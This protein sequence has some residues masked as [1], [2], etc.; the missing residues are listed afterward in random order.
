MVSEKLEFN[1]GTLKGDEDDDWELDDEEYEYLDELWLE[2]GML[3]FDDTFPDVT[4]NVSVPTV[5]VSVT[6]TVDDNVTTTDRWRVPDKVE[7]DIKK[8]VGNKPDS[9]KMQ[10][11]TSKN[12]SGTKTV[13]ENGP[14]AISNSGKVKTSGTEEVQS[15]KK[16]SDNGSD[17]SRL[18]CSSCLLGVSLFGITLLALV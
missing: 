3:D 13:K 5:Y 17:S 8:P 12:L 4:E 2:D 6:P 15:I 11:D 14:N 18:V 9:G 1:N 10:G 7:E 16:T